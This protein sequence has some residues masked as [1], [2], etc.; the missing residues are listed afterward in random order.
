M[1]PESEIV[2]I[3]LTTMGMT[4]NNQFSTTS[5]NKKGERNE[6]RRNQ[7]NCTAAQHQGG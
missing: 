2:P 6:T 4:E 1:V 7:E 5:T 3:Q